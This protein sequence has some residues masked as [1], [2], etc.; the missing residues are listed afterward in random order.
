MDEKIG[1][2]GRVAGARNVVCGV[3]LMRLCLW[4]L[5]C[6]WLWWVLGSPRV[7]GSWERRESGRVEL[8][9]HTAIPHLPQSGCGRAE[10]SLV[11]SVC[12]VN[13]V[14]GTVH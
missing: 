3:A 8:V 11:Y 13:A 9:L 5:A 12:L 1:T 10:Y 7:H 4:A 14:I 6:G 2:R